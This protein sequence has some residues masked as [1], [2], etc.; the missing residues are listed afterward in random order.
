MTSSKREQVLLSFAML[1]LSAGIAF[2]L[3]QHRPVAEIKEPAYVP[4]TVDAVEAIDET[5]RIPISAQGTVAPLRRTSLVAEVPGRVIDVA[6]A[7]NVGGFV[8]AGTTLLQIDPR[9][10]QTA[11]LRAQAAVASAESNL[12]QEKGR[13]EVAMQEWKKLPAG[14]QRSEDAKALYLRKPQLAQAE[15]ELLAAR[16]DLNTARDNLDRT[17]IKAPYAAIISGKSVELGQY[18]AP[19][20]NVAEVFSVDYAEVRLA[21]PQS[22]LEYLDLP[23]LAGYETETR[24]DLSTDVGGKIT[25]W[26]ATL[27]RSEG[28]VDERS[29]VLYTV[30]RI[31]D[32]YALKTKQRPALRVGSFVNA[33]IEGRAFAGLI[34]LPRR[35]LHSGN[36]IWVIDEEHRLRPRTVEV[37]RAGGDQIYVSGGL[38]AG[39][40]VSLTSVD[41]SLSGSEVKV[42]SRIGSDTLRQGGNAAP[43]ANKATQPNT[44]LP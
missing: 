12:A 29:R 18:V 11:L 7:F 39:E 9:D 4:I 32:P 13:A 27:H 16:A 2:T 37:L 31:A 5:L 23:G 24:I 22:K 30:A 25:H 14:S 34:A 6:P 21:I 35:V 1:A 36:Q 33:T 40:L 10:Y 44:T 17:R 20:S 43:R 28:A 38:D 26:P 41:R 8:D 42:V 3:Y 15:S 19:G